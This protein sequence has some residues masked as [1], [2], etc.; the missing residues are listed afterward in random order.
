[1][2][3]EVP[4]FSPILLSG[5]S[6]TDRDTLWESFGVCR[7][8]RQRDCGGCLLRNRNDR[9]DRQRQGRQGHWCGVKC[10]CCPGCPQQ[11]QGE[12]DPQHPVLPE[13]CREIPGGDGRTGCESRCRPDGS[14][15]KRQHRR[16]HELR[17]PDWSRA[18]RLRLLQSRDTGQRPE[19]F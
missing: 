7:T 3:K 2:R 10:R 13:R 1:M 12:P 5:E 18:N 9:H 6:G 16:I 11:C 17:S 14:S 8:H 4:H 19:V 15:Q